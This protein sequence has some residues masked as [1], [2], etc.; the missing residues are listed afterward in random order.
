[1]LPWS[2][3]NLC[4]IKRRNIMNINGMFHCKKSVKKEDFSF[5][6]IYNQSLGAYVTIGTL[7]YRE[8]GLVNGGESFA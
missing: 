8:I 7:F 6:F 5:T 2:S 1:M 4:W 3:F